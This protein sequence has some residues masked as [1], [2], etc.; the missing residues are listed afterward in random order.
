[1]REIEKK[2]GKNDL[3]ELVLCP[4]C[5]DAIPVFIQ[6]TTV[7]DRFGTTSTQSIHCLKCKTLG[8]KDGTY[9]KELEV[10]DQ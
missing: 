3:D 1:M 5:V 4:R 6:T 7:T 9:I 8:H 10:R 2:Y